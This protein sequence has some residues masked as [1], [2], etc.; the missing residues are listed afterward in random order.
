MNPN[1]IA[2]NSLINNSLLP[3]SQSNN[4]LILKRGGNLQYPNN[5]GNPQYGNPMYGNPQYGSP[6]LARNMLKQ[7]YD[8]SKLAYYITIDMEL[9]PGTEISPR[10]KE[11]IEM[12]AKM[13]Y[14]KKGLG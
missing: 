12:Q 6:Y 11:T 5:Y 3:N 9:Y 13:E 8:Q 1:K 14:S 4:Q 10:N 7:N 2:I